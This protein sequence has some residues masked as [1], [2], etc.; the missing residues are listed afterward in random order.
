MPG[1]IPP[2]I[3]EQLERGTPGRTHRV[4]ATVRAEH[5]APLMHRSLDAKLMWASGPLEMLL[6]VSEILLPSDDGLPLAPAQLQWQRLR[7]LW[8]GRAGWRARP[9]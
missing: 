7:A 8:L 6:N 4:M 9:G 2:A 5:L 1:T 3:L